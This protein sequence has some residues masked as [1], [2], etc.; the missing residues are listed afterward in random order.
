MGPKRLA[1]AVSVAMVLAALPAC[2]P[3]SA[4]VTSP[5]PVA[6]SER[7]VAKPPVPPRWPLTGLDAPS[8][9][10]TARRVISVKIENNPAAKPQV[11]LDQADVVY[12]SLAEGGITRFNAIFHSKQPSYLLGPVRS[13]RL[14][15]LDIVPQYGAMFAFAGA[16]GIVYAK[17]LAAGLQEL[18]ETGGKDAYTRVSGRKI[19]HNLFI[20]LAEARAVGKAKGWPVTQ[21]IR[22]FAFDKRSPEGTPTVTVISVPFSETAK[23]RWQYEPATRRYLRWDRGKP[24]VDG[25]TKQQYSARN[26]VVMWAK[27]TTTSKVDAA[28]SPTLDIDLSGKGRAT[29]FRDGMKIEGEWQAS[30]D[31]PPEFRAPDGSAVKL[32][33][34]STWFQVI[35]TSQ[36]ISWQ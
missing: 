9:E 15:D 24:H 12:E 5:W 14:S 3:R 29:V 10:E 18:A 36:N 35:P 2:K 30:A 13:A 23:A 1:A 11:G 17:I 21:G 27:T 7:T 28:G 31:S 8:A 33:P 34:G 4:E 22:P 16:N 6:T 32:A 20:D 26:V 25:Q 19:P